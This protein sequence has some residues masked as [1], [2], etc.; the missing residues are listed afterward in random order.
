MKRTPARAGLPSPLAIEPR[1]GCDLES[2]AGPIEKAAN[3]FLTAFARKQGSQRLGLAFGD[4]CVR[5]AG[6]DEHA[7]LRGGV[8]MN[9]DPVIQSELLSYLGQLPADEQARVV[10]FAR[11]LVTSPT[12]EKSRSRRARNSCVL[13]ER[14][15]TRIW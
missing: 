10:D 3:R 5:I 12:V 7:L 8:V 4:S 9:P 6:G 15:R 14:S 1:A 2:T 11:T 13:R